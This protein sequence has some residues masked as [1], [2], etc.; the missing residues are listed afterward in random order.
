MIIDFKKN[1]LKLLTGISIAQIIPIVFTPILTQYFSPDE[2]GIYGLYI[3]VCSILGVVASFKYDVAIML[4]KRNRDAMNI[5]ILSFFFTFIFSIIFFS[6]LNISIDLFQENETIKSIKKY[7]F[8]LPLSVFLISINQS[9]LVWLNRQKKYI[10][11]ANQ[12][13]LKSSS[14][15]FS[16]LLFGVKNISSGL[17]L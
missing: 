2:F 17:V 14:N 12:N 13:V 3:S 6:I 1:V 9:I 7:Y 4:P 8:I 10:I 5:L 16:A 11:I 15:S